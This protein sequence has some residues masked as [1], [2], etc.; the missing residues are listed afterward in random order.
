MRRREGSL[1][2]QRAELR[3]GVAELFPL[4]LKD[5]HSVVPLGPTTEGRGGSH[6]P[7]GSQGRTQS[8]YMLLRHVSGCKQR[9]EGA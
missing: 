9:A 8:D 1:L 7:R 2:F 6:C 3:D 5:T 4:C